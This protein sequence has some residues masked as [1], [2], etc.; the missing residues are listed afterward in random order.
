MTKFN[1]CTLF[2]RNYLYKGLALYNSLMRNCSEFSLWILCLD[3]I[4]YDLLDRLKLKNVRLI[5]MEDFEDQELLSIKDSR[6][7]IEYCWTCT[8]SL[9]LYILNKTPSIDSIAYIDADVYFY[10]DPSV[11]YEEMGNNSI[12]I[13]KHNY[14]A[15]YRKY[16]KI[17][18]KFNVQFLIFKNDPNALECLNWWRK[19]CLEWC[20]ARYEDNRW[21]DQKY[22]DE[23]S[24]RFKGVWVF[25]HKGAGAAPWNI[26]QYPLKCANNRIFIDDQEL[27]FYHFHQ[28]NILSSE[29]FD[30]TRGYLLPDDAIK[31]IYKP[32]VR[33]INKIITSVLEKNP[34][35]T[36]G[37]NTEY[38]LRSSSL[39]TMI[40][41]M[42]LR[43]RLFQILIRK[44]LGRLW[45]KGYYFYSLKDKA[46]N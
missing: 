26:Q 20:Y 14:S 32:Y 13:V 31:L 28:L 25:T 7:A 39:M 45:G 23:W 15:R 46:E 12:G 10:S 38:F 17:H 9:P 41:N 8:S 3:K 18:G 21:G 30:L 6:S 22:L 37:Y 5:A 1:F 40:K 43:N 33:E 42:F 36:Y 11:L 34:G 27:I 44:K 29:T 19:K 16:E 24:G 2:D 4:T 35:F